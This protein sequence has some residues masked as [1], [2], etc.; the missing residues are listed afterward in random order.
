MRGADPVAA[1]GAGV[2]KVLLASNNKKKLEEL[3]LILTPIVP[4]IEVL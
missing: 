3:R 2:T 1:G 4:G